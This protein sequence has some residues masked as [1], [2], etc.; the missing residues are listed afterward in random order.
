MVLYRGITVADVKAE[1][2][3]KSSSRNDLM[4]VPDSMRTNGT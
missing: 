3:S 2:R 4:M 1:Q